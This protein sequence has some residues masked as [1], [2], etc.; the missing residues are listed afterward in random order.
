MAGK[1]PVF[2]IMA[3]GQAGRLQYEA[4]ALAASLRHTNPDFKGR[5]IIAEP[6]MNHRWDRDPAIRNQEVRKILEELGAEI[7]PFENTVFGCGYPY[8]N[9]IEALSILP[10]G[11]PFLFLD[12]DTIV[13]GNL[14][15]VPFDFN[16]PTAS[17][18]REGT[19][20]TIELYGPG[21][22]QIWGS[23]YEKFGLDFKSS[24]DESYPDEF[25]RRYLYFNAG[26]FYYSC[27]KEFGDTFMK[28]ARA[29]RDDPP[30]ELVCQ[31][32]KPWLDQVALPLTIHALGGGR[33]PEVSDALD[34]EVTCHYRVLPLLF[35][36]ERD[37]VVDVLR[38]SVAPNRIKKVLKTYEPFLRMIY[39]NKGDKVREMFD[40]DDLPRREQA[41]RNRI[42]RANLWMR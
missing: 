2:N 34:H 33:V 26:F 15:K 27:P 32:M 38:Q 41:I 35:A 3:V 9:K 17:M 16:R 8:G 37:E 30:E 39:Q 22:N 36:R 11:E 28:F 25:W 14:S 12:T 4:I 24:L 10:K 23:L 7:V 5:L 19:W 18:K 42:K 13:T 1:A 21:Y 29:I 6:Q 40:R 31:E 20:P